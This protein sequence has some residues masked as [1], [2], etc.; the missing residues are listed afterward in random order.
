MK[1]A[2]YLRVS[3]DKQAEQGLGLDVQEQAIR[4]WATGAVIGRT[5][6]S[7]G[8]RPSLSLQFD[9]ASRDKRPTDDQLDTFNPLF[10]S[11][12]YFTT[13][14]YTTYANLVH[15]KT[16]LSVNPLTNV[17]LSFGIGAE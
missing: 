12:Y 9:A 6:G 1:L 11:G 15:V 8:F 4:A 14:G 3:T 10:P 2:A 13:A 16:D 7:T 5:F 17:K